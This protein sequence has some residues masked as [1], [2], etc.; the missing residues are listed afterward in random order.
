MKLSSAEIKDR[1]LNRQSFWV[2]TESERKVA[3]TM[4]SILSINYT[5]GSDIRGGF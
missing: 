4:A 2:E 5:T 3:C 1:I